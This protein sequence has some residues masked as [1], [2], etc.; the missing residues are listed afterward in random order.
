L[1]EDP[2]T[3]LS[4]YRE[5]C[6]DT[7]STAAQ[8]TSPGCRPP[9]GANGLKELFGENPKAL[10]V[11]A[12]MLPGAIQIGAEGLVSAALEKFKKPESHHDRRSKNCSREARV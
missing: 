1:W 2:L 5:R 4:R 11:I 7:A 3:A 10:T 12:A 6:A 8:R 9:S